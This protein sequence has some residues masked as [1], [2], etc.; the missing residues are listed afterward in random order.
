MFNEYYSWGFVSTKEVQR[1]QEQL[2]QEQ[3]IQELLI[4]EQRIQELLIGAQARIQE[5]LT[6]VTAEALTAHKEAATAQ[7]AR[8]CYGAERG[9]NCLTTAAP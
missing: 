2:I 4:Q 7:T 3:R 6:H 1:I 5:Q 8:G 9:C